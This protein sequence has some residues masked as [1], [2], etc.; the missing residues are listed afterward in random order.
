[1]AAILQRLGLPGGA[2]LCPC[3]PLSDQLVLGERLF[4]PTWVSRAP[5]AAV[6]GQAG[7][8]DPG[9]PVGPSLGTSGYFIWGSSLPGRVL[10]RA[11][12]SVQLVASLLRHTRSPFSIEKMESHG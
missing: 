8:C 5:V 6:T 3:P 4:V 7:A 9:Q 11:S 12:M 10:A 2:G 1:M